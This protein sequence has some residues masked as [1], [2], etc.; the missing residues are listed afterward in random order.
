MSFLL[1]CSIFTFLGSSVLVQA[2][3]EVLDFIDK[4]Q[5]ISYTAENHTLDPEL[6][7]EI[8]P[9][10]YIR[11]HLGIKSAVELKSDNDAAQGSGE[12]EEEVTEVVPQSGGDARNQ[13]VVLWIG[14]LLPFLVTLLL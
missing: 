9:E 7:E 13:G 14:A 11:S 12:I 2:D 5:N 1:I 4:S 8:F 6:E 3:S 10:E